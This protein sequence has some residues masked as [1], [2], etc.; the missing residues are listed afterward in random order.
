MFFDRLSPRK[1]RTFLQKP[2]NYSTFATFPDSWRCLSCGGSG[3]GE[4]ANSSLRKS[5]KPEKVW[6]KWKDADRAKEQ[7]AG[8][9]G[10]S[11][12]P[13]PAHQNHR[14]QNQNLLLCHLPKKQATCLCFFFPPKNFPKKL[15][16]LFHSWKKTHRVIRQSKAFFFIFKLKLIF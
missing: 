2:L 16:N 1:N 6:R 3:G 12:V 4:G 8:L 5:W 10:V 7:S 14:G 15:A 11:C 9:T 13:C